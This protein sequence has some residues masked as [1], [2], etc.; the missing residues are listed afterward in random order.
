MELRLNAGMN[1]A[2]PNQFKHVQ[3]TTKSTVNKEDP[4]TSRHIEKL[5]LYLC[6][7]L[8]RTMQYQASLS[9]SWSGDH[10]KGMSDEKAQPRAFQRPPPTAHLTCNSAQTSATH[11]SC[12]SA[13]HLPCLWPKWSLDH[14]SGP[15]LS[16]GK[17]RNRGQ[18]SSS[19]N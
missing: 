4:A 6:A 8:C 16:T 7:V 2:C 11:H 12:L 10:P 15:S 13:L 3:N 1:Q 9:R 14:D 19:Q 18:H 17:C 5:F